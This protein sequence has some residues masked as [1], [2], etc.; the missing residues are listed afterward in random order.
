MVG[1]AVVVV[2]LERCF[3]RGFEGSHLKEIS[4]KIYTIGGNQL[5]WISCAIEIQDAFTVFGTRQ[6]VCQAPSRGNRN[7]TH[8]NNNNVTLSGPRSL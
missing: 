4:F 1:N 2:V 7:A 5:G 3:P 8:Q 6:G